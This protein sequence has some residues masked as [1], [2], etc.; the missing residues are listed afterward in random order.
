MVGQRAGTY[1]CVPSNSVTGWIIEHGTASP[2]GHAFLVA[3]EGRVLEA[4]PGGVGYADLERYVKMGAVFND[5]EPL[6]EDYRR[7]VLQAGI[8]LI[9]AGYD[10]PAILNLAARCLGRSSPALPVGRRN[11]FICSQYVTVTATAAGHVYCPTVGRWQVSPRTLADRI[12]ARS[13]V[14]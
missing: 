13:W 14:A 3:T 4:R 6:T 11:R 1:G 12:T 10:W 5:D 7:T 9:G 2:Y 8:G